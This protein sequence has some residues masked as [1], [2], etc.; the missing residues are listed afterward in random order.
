MGLVDTGG[1]LLAVAV[2]AVNLSDNAGGIAAVDRAATKSRRLKKIW[3]DSGFNKSFA[4]HCS[5]SGITSQVVNRV[6]AHSFEMCYP[7]HGSWN[8]HGLGWST[9]GVYESTTNQ[10]PP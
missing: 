4:T 5:G 8:G 9:T 3:H 7:A 6:S 1:L 2:V 10:T